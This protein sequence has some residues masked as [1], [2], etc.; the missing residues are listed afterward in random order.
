MKDYQLTKNNLAAFF[1]D[2]QKELSENRA[3]IVTTQS[4]NTGNWSM[5]RL[6]RAWMNT[7]AE[8]MA[9]KGVTMPLYIDSNGN[10]HGKR[11]FNSDDAH[12]LF[13]AKWLGVDE[14]GKRLSWSKCGRDGMRQA[15]KGERFIAL[16]R[17][18]LFCTERGIALLNPRDSEYQEL[19]RKTNE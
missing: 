15:T 1:D 13:T 9:G 17:H 18:E 12:E 8:F 6:W 10:F 3:L 7:T 2:I 5:T 19:A 11:R 16:Q 4:A 14:N